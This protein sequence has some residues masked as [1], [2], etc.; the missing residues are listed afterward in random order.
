MT[1]VSHPLI[2]I[3]Q[4]L[5]IH[6]FVKQARHF[7]LRWWL[8]MPSLSWHDYWEWSY[9]FYLTIFRLW[10]HFS[11]WKF[12]FSNILGFQAGHHEFY[13]LIAKWMEQ[14]YLE[15]FV[16][17]KKFRSFLVLAKEFDVDE[18]T[19]TRSFQIFLKNG[20]H[21]KGKHVDWM[22]VVVVTHLS[23]HKQD[24]PFLVQVFQTFI[25]YVSHHFLSSLIVH[26]FVDSDQEQLRWLH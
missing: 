3:V 8:C 22:K 13:D 24:L 12:T 11:H 18:D 14:T 20:I 4:H 17:N 5:S 2:F 1:V 23:T 16:S 6:I 25:F 21:K 7:S 19:S 15:S 26:I 10:S 9:L